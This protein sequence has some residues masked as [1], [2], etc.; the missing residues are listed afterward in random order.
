MLVPLFE[1]GA[2]FFV[3]EGMFLEGA[4]RAVSSCAKLSQAFDISFSRGEDTP[5]FPAMLGLHS[6]TAEGARVLHGVVRWEVRG[7]DVK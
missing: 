3:A 4:C 2:V 6:E 5:L 1:F 7:G